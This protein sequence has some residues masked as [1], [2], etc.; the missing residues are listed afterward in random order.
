MKVQSTYNK[1]G[2]KI[3]ELIKIVNETEDWKDY[4]EPDTIKLINELLEIQNMSEII[5]INDIS[6]TNLRAKYIAA[7]DRIKAKNS[8]GIRKGK[9]YKAKKLFE[10][11]ETTDGWQ[12]ALTDREILYVDTFKKYKNFYEVGRRLDVSP[13]NVAGTLYGTNQREGV[14]NKIERFKNV[15]QQQN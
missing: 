14:T 5:K 7:L 4:V 11:V 12:T 1:F 3:K 15:I 6:Y 10:L 8:T 13:S 9:S 2:K